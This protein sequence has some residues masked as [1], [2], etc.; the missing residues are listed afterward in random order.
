MWPW[1][2]AALHSRPQ[3]PPPGERTRGAQQRL[4]RPRLETTDE[5]REHR[6]PTMS[7][8]GTEE[9]TF[10]V[11][12]SLVGEECDAPTRSSKQHHFGEH[13]EARPLGRSKAHKRC[14]PRMVTFPG[15][16][17]ASAGREQSSLSCQKCSHVVCDAGDRVQ[18]EAA[19]IRGKPR[20]A[21]AHG[22]GDACGSLRVSAAAQ[23][24][25]VPRGHLPVGQ[26]ALRVVAQTPADMG[27][28]GLFLNELGALRRAPEQTESADSL[29]T[30]CSET[31]ST[32]RP[33]Q[34]ATSFEP[35]CMSCPGGRRD[36]S[37][38]PPA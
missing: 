7:S 34:R 37:A 4:P 36:G 6:A 21:G 2:P 11:P 29:R 5:R 19:C 1:P 9:P 25:D 16:A 33:G 22:V 30:E 14:W 8:G 23:P 18:A 35:A 17:A 38:A 24:P 3:H 28:P 32:R 31:D 12:A 27:L 26:S 20:A 10:L 13:V 15:P